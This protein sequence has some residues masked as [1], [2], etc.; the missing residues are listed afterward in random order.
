QDPETCLRD[1]GAA[2]LAA[3][4]HAASL[5]SLDVT[6]QGIGP[7]GARAMADSPHLGNLRELRLGGNPLGDEGVEALAA[8]THLLHLNKLGLGNTGL[9]VAGLR[10]LLASEIVRR[11]EELDLTGGPVP[12]VAGTHYFGVEGARAIAE[13]A[14]PHL[15]ALC[16]PDQWIGPD[17][18]AA[19]AA[20]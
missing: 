12:F 9:L 3:D 4:P 15:K 5:H 16:M 1:A 19:L 2:Q 10:A 18:V 8:S 6:R 20:S 13:A 17:G 14:L 11:V 7:Q